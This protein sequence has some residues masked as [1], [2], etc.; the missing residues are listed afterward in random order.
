MANFSM[1]NSRVAEKTAQ[2]A[3][4]W[5]KQCARV[6][7]GKSK[8]I[9]TRILLE[10]TTTPSRFTP[11][12][13]LPQYQFPGASHS[14]FDTLIIHAT[15]KWA[16]LL[17]IYPAFV[18]PS[19]VELGRKMTSLD[20]DCNQRAR[21]FDCLMSI[22]LN[23]LETVDDKS[24]ALPFLARLLLNPFFS[25]RK[26]ILTLIFHISKANEIIQL[27]QAQPLEPAELVNNLDTN[28][29]CLFESGSPRDRLR[30]VA[31]EY[32]R[33]QEQV[34]LQTNCVA[35]TSQQ[36]NNGTSHTISKLQ[37]SCILDNPLYLEDVSL[38]L[39]ALVSKPSNIPVINLLDMIETLLHV[40]YGPSYILRLIINTPERCHD[41]CQSLVTLAE[42]LD[43]AMSIS[44]ISENRTTT[45]RAICQLSPRIGFKVQ[46]LALQSR[47]LPS[48]T[49]TLSLDQLLRAHDLLKT[50]EDDVK[51]E[52]SHPSNL[53]EPMKYYE[54]C[55]E[56][57][58]TFVIGLLQDENEITRTWFAKFLKS[59]QH[60]RTDTNH[61]ESV[62][63]EF[64]SQ[65]MLTFKRL[66]AIFFEEDID[67]R[68]DEFKIDEDESDQQFLDRRLIQATS[69]LRYFNCLRGIGMLKINQEESE[70]L[71]SLITCRLKP[72][73]ISVNFVTTGICTL[74]SCSSII[75][76][77][78][79][80]KRAADWLRW[81]QK[82]F[83]DTSIA[84]FL[85]AIAKNFQ[86]NQNN[87]IAELVNSK[88]GMT[89]QI[90]AFISKCK[91]LFAQDTFNNSITSERSAEDMDNCNSGAKYQAPIK[92]WIYKKIYEY[93]E[94]LR[95]EMVGIRAKSI[96]S[97]KI[98]GLKA[99][100]IRC[101]ATMHEDPAS[102]VRII[103]KILILPKDEVWVFVNPLMENWS[104][105]LELDTSPDSRKL[106]KVLT[107][108]W[109]TL[110]TSNPRE[111]WI[112]TINSLRRIQSCKLYA[113]TDYTFDDIANDPLIVLKCD[114]RVFR[115]QRLL[116]IV[117]HILSAFL[118]VSK[119]CLQ[120]QVDEHPN[121]LKEN[122]NL[123]ELKSTLVMAQ[124]SAAI[125]IILEYCLPTD[126]ER[127]ILN[128]REQAQDLTELELSILERYDK[129]VDCICEHLHQVFIVDTNLAKLVHFQTYPSDLLAIT[130]EK[131]PSMHIC[132][133]YIPE[134]LSQPDLPKQ[135]F[136]IQLTSHLCE[137]YAITKSLNCAK[138]CFNVAFTLLQLLPSDKRA[139]FYTPTLPALLR[140]SRVFP[141][142][143]EDA[144][145]ILNQV[146]QVTLA[147]MASTS[148]RLSLSPSTPFEGI[149]RLSWHDINKLMRNLDLDEALYLCI[150]KCQLELKAFA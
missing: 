39:F 101:F 18:F 41:V 16:H 110:N 72:S 32:L 97:D 66:F 38:C 77:H 75:T 119:R 37:K 14:G 126:E 61:H 27:L 23:Q 130:I 106:T 15:L 145:M 91:P 7:L 36:H 109:W 3:S 120:D 82:D 55:Y 113:E 58:L 52:T 24:Y 74:L 62:L 26:K 117:L 105:V 6:V 28:L 5:R 70:A 48:L 49:I 9:F 45:L 56:N 123:E 20:I 134:L 115:N 132:L 127:E 138:L 30:L 46:T 22:N 99:Q 141:I 146:H 88:L 80:E 87:Q 1:P 112:M 64:R 100:F 86:S 51:A 144:R 73:P 60:K 69:T 89:L 40:K 29:D 4:K 121:R 95:V 47:Q 147:H 116:D 57:A 131:V 11:L 104:R 76:G 94:S 124:T 133:D 21:I 25:K 85:T 92:D 98:D 96:T 33:I 137:K 59:S 71:L 128:K 149:D 90:K 10:P 111:L 17:T 102:L 35:A 135:V 44:D 81:L 103:N 12:V 19:T 8:H 143:Q 129:S 34:R 142:L 114:Q 150:K 54:S 139:S 118:E 140:L 108:M 50:I 148:S 78:K 79:E 84:E 93:D 63:A 13:R 31:I 83:S 125:Q 67:E 42:S 43:D 53:I 68:V 65:I 122:R 2:I 107:K 136:V